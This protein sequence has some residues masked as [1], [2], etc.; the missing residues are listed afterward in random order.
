MQGNHV[1]HLTSRVTEERGAI[2]YNDFW[3]LLIFRETVYS[4]EEVED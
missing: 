4:I 1:I 3:Q 2:I